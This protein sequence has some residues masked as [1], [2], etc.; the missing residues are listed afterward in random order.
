LARY[1][2]IDA[3][4]S[5]TRWHLSDADKSSVAGGEAQGFSG[6]VF[7]PE[8]KAQAEAA[9]EAI[10]A[11]IGTADAVVAGVT[12]LSHG[13]AEA[14]WLQEQ[15]GRTFQAARIAV[16]SDIELCCRALF[17]A[18]EGIVVYA[19]TGSIAAHLTGGGTLVTAGGKGVLI[20]DAGG[21][22]WIAVSALRAILRAEDTA[23]GSG[24]KTVLG[25]AM[26]QALGGT[27]W[28][29]VRQ[30]FYSRDRGAVGMLAVP[31]GRAAA[32]G[33]P[34]ALSILAAAGAEL[35]LLARM[36]EGRTGRHAIKL[37]GRAARLH[38]VLFE[39][40]QESLPGRDLTLANAD[41]AAAAAEIAARGTIFAELT[42]A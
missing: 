24:W 41:F 10:A 1:L 25:H 37:A 35:A 4:G 9:I 17:P 27:S 36:L 5:A 23:A 21:G 14:R 19:G 15:L 40:M 7:R 34:V 39:R 33:D 28:P 20:D 13:V 3:G 11:Q 38:P 22:Y 30:S 18:G 12:G 6:Q 2:G 26:G 32:S 16:V 8:A 42:S 31:V 29:T